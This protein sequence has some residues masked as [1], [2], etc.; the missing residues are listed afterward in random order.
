MTSGSDLVFSC[1]SFSQ[2]TPGRTAAAGALAGT[3]S[4]PT[5]AAMAALFGSDSDDDGA[6]DEPRAAGQT[7]ELSETEAAA[8]AKKG[9]WVGELTSS[10]G[11]SCTAGKAAGKLA[12]APRLAAEAG[13]RRVELPEAEGAHTSSRV[14][15]TLPAEASSSKASGPTRP[16]KPARSLSAAL[17]QSSVPE[18]VKAK[19]AAQVGTTASHGTACLSV[20][21]C[22]AAM[23]GPC[24][25]VEPVQ[26]FP[27]R[28][29]PDV[30][31]GRQGT[32]TSVVSSRG[33]VGKYKGG[34]KPRAVCTGAR[35]PGRRAP[36][37]L[38]QPRGGQHPAHGGL[39]PLGPGRPGRHAPRRAHQPALRH[40]GH[41]LSAATGAFRSRLH[42]SCMTLLHPR[43]VM[44][45]F[46]HH[47]CPSLLFCRISAE[48]C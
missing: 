34:S 48:A 20:M 45:P 18:T 43:T 22:H 25:A 37:L 19:L 21:V 14:T 2:G 16:V 17:R 15:G 30:V 3:A 31:T 42:G 12:V 39:Q 26:A 13:S 10:G 27:C 47:V 23:Q 1:L 29:Q 7:T 44:P 38:G 35:H 4:S 5:K 28:P 8:A 33:L 41:V 6:A 36:G 24:Y 9:F 32:C 11:K 46:L 40:A